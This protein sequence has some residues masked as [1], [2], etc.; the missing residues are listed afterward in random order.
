MKKIVAITALVA[1]STANAFAG[2]VGAEVRWGDSTNEQAFTFNKALGTVNA[3]VEVETINEKAE[4]GTVNT[5]TANAGMPL[6]VGNLVIE[7]FVQA[8]VATVSYGPDLS[9]WGGGVKTEIKVAGPVSVGAEYRYRES[10]EGPKLEDQ[11]ATAFVK[12]AVTNNWSA[13]AVYHNHFGD[14]NDKQYGVGV[15]YKF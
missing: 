8:G 4:G 12:L 10:F 1:L 14:S 15:S 11:R 6:S 5:F 3:G 13:K 9:I 7:P 2:D